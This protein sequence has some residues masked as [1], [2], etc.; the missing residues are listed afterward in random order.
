MIL[1]PAN[2]FEAFLGRRHTEAWWFMRRERCGG[3]GLPV[4]ASQSKTGKAP[5]PVQEIDSAKQIPKHWLALLPSTTSTTSDSRHY[6]T[7]HR[8]LDQVSSD[9]RYRR[10][11]RHPYGRDRHSQFATTPDLSSATTKHAL[12]RESCP[13]SADCGKPAT[14][15]S[16]VPL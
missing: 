13:P 3:S 11:Q 15:N 16:N 1:R 9:A 14:A 5:C 12:G 4:V 2:V 10:Q 8:G 7:R 6:A